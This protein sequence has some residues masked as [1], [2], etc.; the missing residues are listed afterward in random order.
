[1]RATSRSLSRASA[2]VSPQARAALEV[3]NLSPVHPAVALL[4]LVKDLIQLV[5][6]HLL[7]PVLAKRQLRTIGIESQANGSYIK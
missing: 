2:G 4:W 5:E 3:R 6:V 1:M 7:P